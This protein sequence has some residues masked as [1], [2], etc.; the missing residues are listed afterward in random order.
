V[1]AAAPNVQVVDSRFEPVVGA[2]FLALE[3]A[4]VAIDASLLARLTPTLP[5]A[6]FF[7]T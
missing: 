2:L 1:R 7:A 4:G 3:L 5:P 6:T